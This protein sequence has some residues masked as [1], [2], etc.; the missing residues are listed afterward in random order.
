MERLRHVEIN[1]GKRCNNRCVF[2]MSDADRDA[3]SPW[4]EQTR[5]R[6]EIAS[7]ARK[8]FRSL[9]FL[10]GEP[11][12][13]PRILEV[14]RH[15]R[16]RGFCRIAFCSNGTRLAD[17]A[18]AGSLIEAGVTR[19]TLSIH[20]HRPALED[21]LTGVPGNGGKKLRAV[22]NLVA[23]ESSGA[24][25]DGLALN[26]VL[27]RLN[28]ADMTEYVRFFKGLGIGDIR[29]NFIWPQ[30]LVRKDRSVVPRYR[31][32][33]PRVLDLILKNSREYRAHLSFGAIPFC[34]VPSVLRSD[35][36]FLR[37]YFDESGLDDSL[38]NVSALARGGAAF[39]HFD[40]IEVKKA[41]CKAK[42]PACRGCRFLRSCEGVYRS[43]L[44]LYGASEFGAVP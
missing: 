15:A 41:T 34:V 3:R 21:R 33:M 31:D 10:G 22:R 20:S 12:V 9:G 7:A 27:C 40:W 24:L 19:V 35:R 36:S 18:F 13:F 14:V 4:A 11:S 32:V 42:P 6:A 1:L 44:E 26:P 2:C 23:L 43:Y 8:G 17:P 25:P 30:A 16:Q 39:E 28:A 29:F 5:V 38:R 37:R